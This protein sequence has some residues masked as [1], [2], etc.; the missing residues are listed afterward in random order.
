MIRELVPNPTQTQG[1]KRS[2]EIHLQDIVSTCSL[3]DFYRVKQVFQRNN[4]CQVTA[5]FLEVKDV[6]LASNFLVSRPLRPTKGLAVGINEDGGV[7]QEAESGE[8]YDE[9]QCAYLMK[10]SVF[11]PPSKAKT[12]YQRA[13]AKN[14]KVTHC[15]VSD[16]YAVYALVQESD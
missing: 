7:E 12:I 15:S 10:L 14:Q 1:V 8:E 3:R 13:L 5:L 6:E 9:R 16:T 2:L 4:F 11:E